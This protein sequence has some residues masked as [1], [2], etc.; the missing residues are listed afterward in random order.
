MGQKA[1]HLRRECLLRDRFLDQKQRYAHLQ[2]SAL[3]TAEIPLATACLLES[4]FRYLRGPHQFFLLQGVAAERDRLHVTMNILMTATRYMSNPPLW[5]FV[6][7]YKSCSSCLSDATCFLH[8]E[9]SL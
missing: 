4:L 2:L 7:A 1:A 5:Q 6:L 8:S 3:A 9:T